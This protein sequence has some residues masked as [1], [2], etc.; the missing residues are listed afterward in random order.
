M[1]K[2]KEKLPEEDEQYWVLHEDT[3]PEEEGDGEAQN[4]ESDK[5]LE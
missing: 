5:E 1:T 2:K 4:Y 3:K